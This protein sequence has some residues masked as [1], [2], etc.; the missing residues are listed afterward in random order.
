MIQSRLPAQSAFSEAK[1]MLGPGTDTTSA[2]LTHILWGLAHDTGY[3][4]ALAQDLARAGWPTEMSALEVV[5][6]L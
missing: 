1:E 4:E 3:Q 2:T 5:P 6:R